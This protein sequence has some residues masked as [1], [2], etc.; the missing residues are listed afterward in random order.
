VIR[1]EPPRRATP[2]NPGEIVNCF[3]DL[4]PSAVSAHPD[5]GDA[6]A[7]LHG[8]A[9]DIA[10]FHFFIEW[11]LRGREIDLT[12]TFPTKLAG[13]VR[14]RFED[15]ARTLVRGGGVARGRGL[16]ETLCERLGVMPL[17]APDFPRAVSFSLGSIGVGGRDAGVELVFVDFGPALDLAADPVLLDRAFALSAPNESVEDRNALAVLERIS[18]GLELAHVGAGFRRGISLRKA[19][20]RGRLADLARAAIDRGAASLIATQAHAL[21]R[22]ARSADHRTA[23]LVVDVA[24]G[25]LTRVGF[26]LNFH[27]DGAEGF[28]DLALADALW[29]DGVSGELRRDAERLIALGTIFRRLG[30]GSHA[31]FRIS[32]LKLSFDGSGHPE[33]K[34][35]LCFQRSLA[36]SL[37][38]S[39]GVDAVSR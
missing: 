8:L 7:Y 9:P 32:H 11:N 38:G 1:P 37:S 27:L 26:E 33:W 21:E 15:L 36:G 31:R 19:Y 16:V 2:A 10:S 30:D 35:Y 13:R 24:G 29:L 17:D 18:T 3:Q 14:I 12:F 34:A 6:L 4:L 20:L 5:F 39:E 25:R 23:H 28:A 22:L